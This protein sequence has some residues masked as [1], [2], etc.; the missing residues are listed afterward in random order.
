[1]T[2]S[3]KIAAYH[4]RICGDVPGRYKSWEHCFRFF[5]QFATPVV[6][7]DRETAALHL[8]FYLASWGMYRGSSFLLRFD[9]TI[10]RAAVDGLVQPR[11]APLWHR[12]IGGSEHDIEH[13]PLILEAADAVREAYKPFGNATDTLVTKVL[14]GTLACLPATDRLFRDGFAR[15]DYKYSR[16]NR[17]FVHSVVGF[18][19]QKLPVLRSEQARIKG[20]SGTHYPL[21]KLIDMYF[22]QTGYELSPEFGDV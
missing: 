8:A 22:W 4:G 2:I 18:C 7:V 6:V 10:H 5:R 21:M 12:D 19:G 11:F 1:M 3:V 9:Y 20:I 17:K 16:L 13:V 14:L 15:S